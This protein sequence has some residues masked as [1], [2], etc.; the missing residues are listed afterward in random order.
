MGK[1]FFDYNVG[2]FVHTISDNMAINADGDML[3]RVGNNM[4]MDIETRDIHFISE[5]SDDDDD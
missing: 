2:D 4:A 5:W 3:M 1:N